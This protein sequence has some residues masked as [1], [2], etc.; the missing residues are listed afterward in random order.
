LEGLWL[1][2]PSPKLI[3]VKCTADVAQ[4]GEHLREA[5]S[6]NPVPSLKK[7]KYMFRVERFI[8]AQYW[9]SKHLIK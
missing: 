8:T 5:L 7:K 2:T 6:S 9:K 3:K 4:A 1:E